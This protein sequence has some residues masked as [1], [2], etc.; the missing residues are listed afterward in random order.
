LKVENLSVDFHITGEL[1]LTCLEV[2]PSSK[3][4]S[5]GQ[6][7]GEHG[8]LWITS[9]HR[10]DRMTPTEKEIFCNMWI[11]YRPKKGNLSRELTE[12]MF[13]EGWDELTQNLQT[14][15]SILKLKIQDLE[16]I[17]LALAESLNNRS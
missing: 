4:P 13:S 6:G 14:E 5:K 1:S 16:K 11:K 15:N 9:I 10:S 12:Q 8:I 3:V 2:M 7:E 17:N